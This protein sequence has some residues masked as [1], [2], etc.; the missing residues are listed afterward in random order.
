MKEVEPSAAS[1]ESPRG[2][3]KILVMDDED[4]VREVAGAMLQFLGYEVGFAEDGSEAIARYLEAKESGRPFDA[5]LMDLT[6]PGK[7]GGR[8]AIQKLI[9]L[10]PGVKAI[11]S[12]G[13]S[14]D[15]IMGDFTQY[16]FKGVIAKPYKME[17]LSQTVRKVIADPGKG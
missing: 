9:E 15:P 17:E 1:E 14:I 7:L 5:L 4:A 10:D 11:V 13:Y 8:E 16:G 3:G 12:S 2:K 6:I